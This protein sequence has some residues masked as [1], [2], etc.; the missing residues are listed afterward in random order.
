MILIRR[1]RGKLINDFYFLKVLIL[2][3]IKSKVDC[4]HLNDRGS[5]KFVCDQTLKTGCNP[6]KNM[7]VPQSRFKS[8]LTLNKMK[9]IKP[10]TIFW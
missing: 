1:K 7:D 8:S 9:I 4:W 3:Q 6:R 5:N 2:E 10:I